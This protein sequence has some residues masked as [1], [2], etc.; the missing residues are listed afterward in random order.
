MM[1]TENVTFLKKERK[2]L[3][4]SMLLLF[5][6]FFKK[7]RG[8]SGVYI[9]IYNNKLRQGLERVEKTQV[10]YLALAL[11]QSTQYTGP[12]GIRTVLWDIFRNYLCICAV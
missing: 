2:A 4:V 3:H 9:C 10:V 1:K 12:A 6:F 7:L 8:I 5:F 11:E